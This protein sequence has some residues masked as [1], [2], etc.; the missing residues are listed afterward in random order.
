[1]DVYI[2]RQPIFDRNLS[3]FGYEL[4]YRKSMNNF[5]EGWDDTQ[6]TAELINNA[7]LTMHFSELTEGTRAFINFS[8]DMLL[9][10][11]PRLLPSDT[12]IIEVLETVEVTEE[13]L[14]AL[15]SLKESGYT[16]VLDDFIFT[17]TRLPLLDIADMVKVELNRVNK[18]VQK[19]MIE[20]YQ[21]KIK[22][23][24][25][26]VETR[27]EFQHALDMGYDY[28]QGYFFSKPVIVKSKEI[29]YLNINLLRILELLYHNEPDFDEIRE[30][31]V[32]DLGLSY[33]LLRLANSVLMGKHHKISS[34]KH[35]MVQLGLMEMRKW[36]Y[37]IMLKDFQVI[38]NK[39]LI[40]T[41]LIRAKMME[42][43]AIKQGKEAEKADYFLTGMFSEID[44]LTNREMTDIVSE[45][46]LKE[47]VRTAL[48]GGENEM[49]QTLDYLIAR[50]KNE[51]TEQADNPELMAIYL[52]ALAW[53]AEVQTV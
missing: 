37:I 14:A 3:V 30:V 27:E 34:L 31:V 11:I 49:K 15:R 12:V 29:A 13:L 7:F 51:N 35:G 21:H 41:C 25:E 22:F 9:S 45:L 20:K 44:V 43:I 32:T 19:L 10:E 50:E 42:L 46:P 36:I 17:Q 47:T 1:M 24:A 2:A 23:L 6:A 4:L 40:K 53:I 8:E 48:L 33:K 5:Y 18:V 38:E 52:E 39:E 16:I 26:K 28:F